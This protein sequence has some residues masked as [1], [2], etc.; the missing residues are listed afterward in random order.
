VRVVR[1]YVN[2]PASAASNLRSSRLRRTSTASTS[3][4]Q[5]MLGPRKIE[6]FMGRKIS[7][8]AIYNQQYLYIYIYTIV[9]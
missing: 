2:C 1:F 5:A 9:I 7:D 6:W 3:I 8:R 4:A